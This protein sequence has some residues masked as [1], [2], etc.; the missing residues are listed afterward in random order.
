MP[1]E[2]LT[3]R[4]WHKL[5]KVA[6][7]TVYSMAKKGPLPAFKVAASGGFGASILIGGPSSGGQMP[8]ARESAEMAAPC[9]LNSFNRVEAGLGLLWAA[10]RIREFAL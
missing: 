8:E 6:E 4:R 1:D 3:L 10:I 7:M 9:R 5:L 2:I